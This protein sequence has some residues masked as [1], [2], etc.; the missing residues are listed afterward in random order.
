MQKENRHLQSRWLRAQ[1]AEFGSWIPLWGSGTAGAGVI[2]AN[3]G[4]V[5]PGARGAEAGVVGHGILHVCGIRN[6]FDF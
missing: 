3:M 6:R 2:R 4:A 1:M 5:G